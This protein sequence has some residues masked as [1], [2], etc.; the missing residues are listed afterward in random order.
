[1]SAGYSTKQ[2]KLCSAGK[3]GTM[4][5]AL[6]S[7]VT[8]I[9]RS[10]P[11]QIELRAYNIAYMPRNAVKCQTLFTDGAS[12]LKGASAGLVLI[13]PAR[14]EYTYAIRLNFTSNNN[15]A[16]YEALLASLRIAEKMKHSTI[17]TKEILV[18]VLNAKSVEAQE[19]NSVVEEEEDNWMTP[20]IKCLEEGIWPKAENEARA[21]RM[22]INQYVMEEGVLFKKSYLSPMLRDTENEAVRLMMFPLSLTGEAK[23][24]LDEVN[25][26]TIETWDELRTTFISQNAQ[27]LPWSQSVQ[28]QFYKNLLSWSHRNNPRSSKC[29]SRWYFPL[30]NTKSSLSASGRQSSNNSNTDKIMARMGAMTLKMDAQYKELQTHA[31]NTK[32]GL[33]EDDIPMSREEE[34]KF[35]QTFQRLSL[36]TLNLPNCSV[37]LADRSFQYPVEIAKNML[38]E[39]GKFTFPADF[40]ILEMEEDSKVPLILGRPFLHNADAVI[41]VKQKQ[42]NLGVGTERMIFNINYA[43]KHSY[44]NDD[45]CFSIN[46]INEILEEDFDALLDEGSKILHSIKGTLL[47]EE[48][49]F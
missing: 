44:S 49:F 15:E 24:W 40:V 31:K 2:K 25:E 5:V 13:D 23:T 38:I 11:H 35:M 36:E 45:T 47:E 32:L 26:G 33:D 30:L 37:R 20:I 21:L 16:E 4:F 46:V 34:A 9:L 12:S 10:S 28:R 18:E 6:V 14:T 48:I 42:L 7:E 39:V 3:I 19:M 8:K 41:R 1:M 29:R 22:K 17:L 43:M 27:K